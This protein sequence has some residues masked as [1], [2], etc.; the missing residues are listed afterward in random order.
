MRANF[1]YLIPDRDRYGVMRYYVRRHGRK[2]RIREKPGTEGFHLA[3]A[4]AMLALDPTA[5]EQRE[6]LKHASA[7]TLGWLAARYF[8]SAEFRRLDP[9]SQRVRRSVIED[10]LREPRKPGADDVMRDCP[11]TA[12]SSAHV[13]MLRDRKSEM[14]GAANNRRKYLSS[15]FGWA[16]ED[17]LMRS[18]PAREIRRIGYASDGIHTWTPVRLDNSR[19]GTRSAP[20]R[21]SRSVS[22]SISESVAAMSSRSV[23]S[24]SK[25]DG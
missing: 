23:A 8:A 3:Y 1:P 22:C 24:M 6:V 4:E 19:P 9:K 25:M 5:A 15:M 11:M 14:P 21:G 10:C 16:V 18:N 13:K 17:G 2:I 12:L 20:R 7:G